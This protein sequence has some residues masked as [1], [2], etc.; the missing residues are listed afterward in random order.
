MLSLPTL[1]TTRR[2]S[3]PVG[4]Y[5]LPGKDLAGSPFITIGT[6]NEGA[7]CASLAVN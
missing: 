4:F 3:P 2:L 6:L 7:V 1:S 5:H